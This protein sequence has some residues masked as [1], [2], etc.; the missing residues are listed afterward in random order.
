MVLLAELLSLLAISS[1]FLIGASLA[2]LY[3]TSKYPD[4]VGFTAVFAGTGGLLGYLL[5]AFSAWMLD[6]SGQKAFSH[7]FLYF[8]TGIAVVCT[9][10]TLYRFIWLRSKAKSQDLTPTPLLVIGFGSGILLL[11]IAT[12]VSFQSA[13]LPASGWDA[14][15]WWVGTAKRFL[16]SDANPESSQLIFQYE[17]YHPITISLI[18]S[19]S[20]YLSD[21]SYLGLG[22]LWPWQYAWICIVLT[23]FGTLRAAGTYKSI[24]FFAAYL[25]AS[26]PLLENHVMLAGYSEIWLTAVV[27]SGCSLILIGYFHSAKKLVFLGLG[28]GALAIGIKNTGLAYFGAIAMSSAFVWL[29]SLNGK[30]GSFIAFTICTIGIGVLYFGVDL[31][32][33]GNEISVIP[34]A[35]YQI[36]FAGRIW[37]PSPN[38]FGD[39]T[40]NTLYAYVFNSS[41]S[42]LPVMFFTSGAIVL[43]RLY[44]SRPITIKISKEEVFLLGI[45]ATLASMLFL[46]QLLFDYAFDHATPTNDTGNSRF[47]L[48][49]VPLVI[50]LT[51]TSITSFFN[52]NEKQEKKYGKK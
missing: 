9:A 12:I 35:P 42:L 34:N 29:L 46:S 44:T 52:K 49:M 50:M 21:R 51:F 22:N 47:S 38:S 19:Y 26:T 5:V 31:H 10:A 7:Q 20:G 18:G 16:K 45:I 4:K 14:L 24:A 23:V 2:C 28:I 40:W 39:V 36:H 8:L 3:A 17:H 11:V 6:K 27:C 33:W 48:P 15:S 25:A 41:F 13:I 30:I 43:V 37:H 32:I 1:P